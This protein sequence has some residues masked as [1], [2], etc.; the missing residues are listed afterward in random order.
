MACGAERDEVCVRVVTRTAGGL[1]VVYLKIRHRS[2]PLTSPSVA[3]QDLL[4]QPL[5]GNRIQPQ[6]GRVRG[7]P[8]S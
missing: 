3:T 2:T 4:P 1:R 5:V 8:G 6:A 7:D